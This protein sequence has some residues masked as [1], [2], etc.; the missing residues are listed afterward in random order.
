MTKWAIP[1][2]LAV[3]L[4]LVAG[5]ASADP[6]GYPTDDP[7]EDGY[8]LLAEILEVSGMSASWR[9]FFTAAARRESRFNPNTENRKSSEAAAAKRAYSYSV[10]K[11]RLQE[12]PYGASSYTWGSG[13]WWGMFP[14]YGMAAFEGTELAT[15]DPRAALHDPVTSLVMALE[16]ARRIQRWAAFDGTWLSL[17][18]G[19]ANP[20]KMGDP[21]FV[22]RV[23]ERFAEDLRAIGA[24]E[25]FMHRTID[26]MAWYP[27]PIDLY[28][29]LRGEVS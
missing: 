29:Y 9:T 16:Y 5:T 22:A 15:I 8:T 12:S 6:A 4:L 2:V 13:G 20:S 25:R 7:D 3:G 26:G 18:V 21:E 1:A 23:A 17:R 27:G 28:N 19:W 14:A 24:P 10:E 11:G